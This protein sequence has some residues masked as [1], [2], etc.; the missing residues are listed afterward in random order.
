MQNPWKNFRMTKHANDVVREK[1]F[2]KADIL[3]TLKSPDEVYESR[4][5]AGQWRITGNGLCIVGKPE[6]DTFVIITIYL[7][8]V[9]TELRPDQIANGVVIRR[10]K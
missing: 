7:D 8:R 4:M 10:N 3:R 5:Y 1:S 2:S 6:G 9:I